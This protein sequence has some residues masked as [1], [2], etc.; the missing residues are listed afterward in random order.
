MITFLFSG[1]L[2]MMILFSIANYL[3]GGNKEFL[4][5]AGY[6][7][8]VGGMLFTKALYDLRPNATGYFLEGYLDYVMQ[9]IGIIFYMYFMQ[10]FLVTKQNHPFLFKLYNIGI[11][12]SFISIIA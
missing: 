7:F 12:L 10:K 9:G 5:Y 8:F 6:A 1:L 11:I 4:Y 3:Q 2:L